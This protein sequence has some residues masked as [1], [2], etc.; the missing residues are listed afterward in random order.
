M[1]IDENGYCTHCGKL[2]VRK[3]EINIDGT[4]YTEKNI[5][6]PI[7]VKIAKGLNRTK[8]T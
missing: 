8:I 1:A 6:P 2:V 7:K 5:K 3:K 4:E